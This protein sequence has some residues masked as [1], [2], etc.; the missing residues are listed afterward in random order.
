MSR[1]P[2]DRQGPG[3]VNRFGPQQ[4]A[5]RSSNGEDGPSLAPSAAGTGMTTKPGPFSRLRCD[6]VMRCTGSTCR[7][8]D[9]SKVTLPRIRGIDCGL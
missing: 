2:D 8:L 6:S 3:S 1:M 9:E 4:T 7:S 5:R